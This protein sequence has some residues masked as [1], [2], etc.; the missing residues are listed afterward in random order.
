MK[1]GYRLLKYLGFFLLG[2]FSCLLLGFTVV[3][4]YSIEQLAKAMAPEVKSPLKISAAKNS[5]PQNIE[6][7][8]KGESPINPNLKELT[9]IS[10]N[11]VD[12]L[13][14]L[15]ALAQEI[16][17]KSPPE[18][19][20]TLCNPTA[21]DH[22]KLREERSAYLVSYYKQQGV[23][24]LEDPLFRLRL[25]EIGFISNLFPVS[26]R[27]LLNQIQGATQTGDID[28][29]GKLNLAVKLQTA[30]ANELVSFYFHRQELIQNKEQLKTLRDLI[31][32][33]QKGT[34]RN[35]VVLACRT[36]HAS[37]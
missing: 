19:C 3:S 15:D 16:S 36:Y 26:F 8:K 12:E 31:R 34:S 2:I 1:F 27:S 20:S 37:K 25:K 30:F 11:Y 35:Q 10:I 14:L 24:A 28:T 9:H 17:Q 18:I 23:R 13:N 4:Y 7:S 32:S 6:E 21:M 22:E 5:N 33:C 29:S